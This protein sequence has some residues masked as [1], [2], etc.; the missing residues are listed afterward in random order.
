MVDSDPALK[1][2]A[3]FRPPL[4]VE[5]HVLGFSHA[6][7]VSVYW[8]STPKSTIAGQKVAWAQGILVNHTY[9]TGTNLIMKYQKI[10][11]VGMV[12]A[13]E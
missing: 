3:K 10:Y 9:A 8:P 6:S 1:R 12:L 4:R 11:G 5:K 2:R 13:M 7:I